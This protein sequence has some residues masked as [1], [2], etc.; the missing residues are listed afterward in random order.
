M[1]TLAMKRL[2]MK[3]LA[4]AMGLLMLVADGTVLAQSSGSGTGSGAR[5][6]AEAPRGHR[7]P[8]PSDLPKAD[9]AEDS[10]MSGNM[11]KEDREL[12]RKIKSICR[13]C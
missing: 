11:S 10:S 3:P 12:D 13:G 1:K 2:P 8:R 5:G 7:Q 4:I 9:Q 6:S